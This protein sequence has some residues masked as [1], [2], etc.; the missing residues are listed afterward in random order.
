MSSNGAL[1]L[2]VIFI[3]FRTKPATRRTARENASLACRAVNAKRK[4]PAESAERLPIALNNE[5]SA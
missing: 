1:N 3:I 2:T 5:K 4:M